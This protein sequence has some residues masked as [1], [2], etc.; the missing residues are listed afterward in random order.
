MFRNVKKSTFRYYKWNGII[1]SKE[2]VAITISII[3]TVGSDSM[4]NFYF[5]SDL[6]KIYSICYK[7]TGTFDWYPTA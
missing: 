5:L 4:Y 6:S 2:V 1:L 3:A 7:L